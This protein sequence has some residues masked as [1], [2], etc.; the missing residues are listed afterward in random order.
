[1][2][3]VKTSLD[4][5]RNYPNKKDLGKE[6]LVETSIIGNVDQYAGDRAAEDIIDKFLKIMDN[7]Y[8]IASKPAHTRAKGKSAQ[9]F[10]MNPDRTEAILVLNIGLATTKFLLERIEH[11]II[12]VL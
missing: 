11:Y 7:A 5:I 10:S 3:E 1:M 6:L 8:W 2:D 12:T 9:R 4:A